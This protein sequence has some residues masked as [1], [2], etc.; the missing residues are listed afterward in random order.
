MGDLYSN[1][2][3]KPTLAIATRTASADGTAVDRAEDG[4]LFQSAVVVVHTGAITDGTHTIEV[5]DSD[6]S[7]SGFAAVADEF[8]QG[9]EPAIGSS[10][11]NVLYEIGYLGS[12]R[13]IR[14]IVTAAGTTSGGTYGAVVILGDPRV[15]PAVRN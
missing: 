2:L 15:K 11:D 13:Y 12:K 9:T 7:G 14:A 10:D 3:V 5:Q 8:L 6:A 1:I 4:S